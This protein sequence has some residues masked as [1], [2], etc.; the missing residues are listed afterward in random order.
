MTKPRPWW[1]TYPKEY[2][3]AAE[4]R[5]ARKRGVVPPLP[6]PRVDPLERLE[7]ERARAGQSAPSL[8][9]GLWG[10]PEAQRANERRRKVD[11]LL[12]KNSPRW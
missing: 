3:T 8:P 7:A 12:G 1:E 5:E 4:W 10:D 9:G 2:W 11:E 6:R